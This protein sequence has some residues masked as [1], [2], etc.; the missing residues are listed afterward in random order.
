[1]YRL[2]LYFDDCSTETS[3][4]G[5]SW[6]AN[7]VPRQFFTAPAPSSGDGSNDERLNKVGLNIS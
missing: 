2:S 7:T 5:Q 3:F 4:P 1:M 6:L